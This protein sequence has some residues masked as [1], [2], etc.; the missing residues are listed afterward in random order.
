[1]SE[2]FAEHAERTVDGGGIGP[3]LEVQTDRGSADNEEDSEA[4]SENDT[5]RRHCDVAYFHFEWRAEAS[6]VVMH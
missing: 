5:L 6:G 2:I 4:N 3:R 1:M